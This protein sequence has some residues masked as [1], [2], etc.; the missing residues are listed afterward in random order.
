MKYVKTVDV[1]SMGKNTEYNII[2][3]IAII[4]CLIIINKDIHIFVQ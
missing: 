1:Q 3:R 4:F 2:A